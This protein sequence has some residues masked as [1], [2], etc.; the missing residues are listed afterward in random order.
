M[1]ILGIDP[2]SNVLANA[3]AVTPTF[4]SAGREPFRL[5][6][7]RGSKASQLAGWKAG[8]TRLNCSHLPCGLHLGR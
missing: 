6:S 1:L 8:V 3:S 2:F 5:Q 7:R 4:L